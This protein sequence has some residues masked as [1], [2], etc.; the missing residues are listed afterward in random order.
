MNFTT[1][2][3][4]ITRLIWKLICKVELSKSEKFVIAQKL[5]HEKFDKYKI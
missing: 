2:D 1:I 3:Q 4:K 5:Y